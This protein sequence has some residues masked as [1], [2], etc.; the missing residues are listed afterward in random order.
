ML[1]SAVNDAPTE[2]H[3]LKELFPCPEFILKTSY[4]TCY[5]IHEL[6]MPHLFIHFFLDVH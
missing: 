1:Q 6:E 2:V 3:I 4:I 5:A